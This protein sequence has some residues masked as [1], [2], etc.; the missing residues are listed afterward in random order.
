MRGA[1][2]GVGALALGFDATRESG[3]PTVEYDFDTTDEEAELYCAI[4]GEPIRPG[5]WRGPN[6]DDEIVHDACQ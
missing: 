1:L 3:G 2:A 4:C 5:Q 6:E